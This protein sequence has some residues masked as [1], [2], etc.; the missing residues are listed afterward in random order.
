M[1]YCTVDMYKA[2][3]EVVAGAG[4]QLDEYTLHFLR[5]GEAT[6]LFR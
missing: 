2:L 3:R 4:L 5:I 1:P 6:C